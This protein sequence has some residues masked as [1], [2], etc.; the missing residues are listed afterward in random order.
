MNDLIETACHNAVQ[1]MYAEA[2]RAISDQRTPESCLILAAAL[3][4]IYDAIYAEGIKH[5]HLP[6][7]I[8]RLRRS[9]AP[10]R[11]G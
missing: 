7:C 1:A 6:A 8:D 5:H 4:A 10:G 3:E 9:A 11:V 2:R